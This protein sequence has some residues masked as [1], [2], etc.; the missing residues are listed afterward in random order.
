MT[1]ASGIV[2]PAQ[3]ARTNTPR[4]LLLGTQPADVARVGVEGGGD[5]GQDPEG[6]EDPQQVLRAHPSVAS[7]E[8]GQRVARDA[9]P[10]GQLDL[11]QAPQPAPDGD[12]VSDAA[13]RPANRGWHRAPVSG[14]PFTWHISG[15][16]SLIA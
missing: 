4:Q 8:A 13:Q 7:L 6:T 14:F 9:G 1:S 15:I 5:A 3:A 11:R 16:L 10:V 12:V 2:R